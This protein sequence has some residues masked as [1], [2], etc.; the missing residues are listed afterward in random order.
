MDEDCV[1]KKKDAIDAALK[2]LAHRDRTCQEI[3]LHLSEKGYDKEEIE[4]A[5]TY[6]FDMKYLDDAAYVEKYMEYAVSKGKGRAKIKHELK[7]K[8]ID[9]DLLEDLL[10]SSESLTGQNERK[11]AYAEAV[12]I[13]GNTKL[14]FSTD[15]DDDLDNDFNKKM[16]KYK[17]MQKVKAK[18]GRRL[19]SLGYS[20]DVIFTT[21]EEIFSGNPQ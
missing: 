1:K 4:K 8:G 7:E 21:I 14:K 15:C 17:E 20:R 18:V 3:R 5:V 6:L 12:K 19:E 16:L 13:L 9:K 11:R 10:C 2:Y